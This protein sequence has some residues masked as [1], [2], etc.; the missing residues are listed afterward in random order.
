M[1]R[2]SLFDQRRKKAGET[3]DPD[4]YLRVGSAV[5][6]DEVHHRIRGDVANEEGLRSGLIALKLAAD[7]YEAEKRWNEAINAWSW[8][9]AG[10]DDKTIKLDA[11]ENKERCI[12]ELNHSLRVKV[13]PC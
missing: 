4:E 11:K 8:I 2:L 9:E 5:I 6:Q 13:G 1:S 10:S 12:T 7:L 3:P